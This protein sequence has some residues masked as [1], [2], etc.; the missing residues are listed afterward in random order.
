MQS[1]K[2]DFLDRISRSLYHQFKG[3]MIYAMLNIENG[4][5]TELGVAVIQ[6]TIFVEGDIVG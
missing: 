6:K 2:S 3:H 5:H 4:L 1:M